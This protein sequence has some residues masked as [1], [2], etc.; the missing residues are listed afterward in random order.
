MRCRL[1]LVDKTGDAIDSRA[2]EYFQLPGLCVTGFL[3]AT[4]LSFV[5]PDHTPLPSDLHQAPE[6]DRVRLL[7]GGVE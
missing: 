5:A 2:G 6:A 1:C 7:S 4:H 3:S